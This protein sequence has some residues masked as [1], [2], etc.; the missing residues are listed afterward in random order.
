[1]IANPKVLKFRQNPNPKAECCV[2]VYK[3]VF[4]GGKGGMGDREKIISICIQ[5]FIDM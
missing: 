1:M 4:R 5:I 2:Q 3:S